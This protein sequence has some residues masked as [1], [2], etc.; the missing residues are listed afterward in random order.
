M[1]KVNLI[2]KAR[3]LRHK[4]TKAEKMLWR[5]LRNRKLGIKFRRQHPLEKFILDFYAPEIKLCVE[6]DG[7]SH[8]ENLEYDKLR[9]EY[10][11]SNEIRT[12]RFW[13]R[14]VETNL[15][16]VLEKIKKEIK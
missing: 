8:K 9:T 6:L 15:E 16:N 3:Y 4:E 2:V 12:I 7:S 13:N 5:E 10:L 14:E 1:T 11:K